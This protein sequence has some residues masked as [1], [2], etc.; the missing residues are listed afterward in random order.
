MKVFFHM[1][2]MLKK[3]ILGQQKMR[4]EKK[5]DNMFQYSRE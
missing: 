1:L 4:N 5:N 3:D 2:R